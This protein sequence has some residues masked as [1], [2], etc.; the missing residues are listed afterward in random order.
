SR[1]RLS[2]HRPAGGLLSLHS[3]ADP[4]PVAD[5]R[6]GI[7]AGPRDDGLGRGPR[8]AAQAKRDDESEAWALLVEGYYRIGQGEL[9]AARVVLDRAEDLSVGMGNL[10]RRNECRALLAEIA[11]LDGDLARA[12]RLSEET[13][14]SA[15]ALRDG[16]A[17]LWG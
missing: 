16:Q 10:R 11:I 5:Q 6:L 2:H 12:A 14:A 8:A 1:D 3:D 7:G 4:R 13:V 15:R 9:A 17:Q